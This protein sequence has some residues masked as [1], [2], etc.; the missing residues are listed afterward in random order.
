MNLKITKQ[1]YLLI[2]ACCSC[3]SC[4]TFTPTIDHC[5]NLYSQQQYAK[6][7]D[8]CSSVAMNDSASM[9]KLYQ[10][11]KTGVAGSVDLITANALLKQS[12]TLGYP[13]A[14]KDTCSGYYTGSIGLQ[15][16]ER[17]I[18]WCEKSYQRGDNGALSYLAN[19]YYKQRN[20]DNALFYFLK[21]PNKSPQ[22]EYIIGQIYLKKDKSPENAYYWIRK[23]YNDKNNDAKIFANAQNSKYGKC[24][25]EDVYFKSSISYS[26]AQQVCKDINNDKLTTSTAVIHTKKFFRTIW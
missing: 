18:Y 19:I 24:N 22:T 21:M 17:A 26:E 9:Y 20:Y 6:Y 4:S 10:I 14:M 16:Y 3:T 8:N 23:A 13:P 1:N 2:L 12:A 11:H 5:N 25:M 7:V 15:D